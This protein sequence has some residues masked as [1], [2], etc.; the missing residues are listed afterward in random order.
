MSLS[1]Q[2]LPYLG[3]KQKAQCAENESQADGHFDSRPLSSFTIF[4][5]VII[6]III[7]I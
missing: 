4:F 5:C 6:I 7:I 3:C 2:T 1:S